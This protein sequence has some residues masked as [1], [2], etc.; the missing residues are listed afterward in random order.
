LG[1][2]LAVWASACRM[3]ASAAVEPAHWQVNTWR[4]QGILRPSIQPYAQMTCWFGWYPQEKGQQR[5]ND[6]V[7]VR[8]QKNLGFLATCSLGSFRVGRSVRQM[9]YPWLP[10]NGAA[11]SRDAR[12]SS[13]VHR[14]ARSC[15]RVPVRSV[16]S[17]GCDAPDGCRKVHGAV[18]A[19]R[20]P[21]G[22][23]V[24]VRSRRTRR[25]YLIVSGSTR[26]CGNGLTF[27][28][29]VPVNIMPTP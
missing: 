24:R 9:G 23:E 25:Y 13:M 18:L 28:Y 2:A 27:A 20:E 11:R 1:L 21:D 16:G 12:C 26:D 29:S 3:P 7:R 19:E 5:T 15:W 22:C 10:A 4:H 14:P 8:N 17:V 6:D